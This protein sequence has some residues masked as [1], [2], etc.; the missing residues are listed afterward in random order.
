[1]RILGIEVDLRGWFRAA[2]YLVIA[3]TVNRYVGVFPT[4][5]SAEATGPALPDERVISGPTNLRS[6]TFQIAQSFPLSAI[7]RRDVNVNITEDRWS[8][9]PGNLRASTYHVSP[10]VPHQSNHK[11]KH[12]TAHREEMLRRREQRAAQL[13]SQ[14]QNLMPQYRRRR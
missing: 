4:K 1:M 12:T 2:L 7:S 5:G 10:K 11:H 6:S 8:N 3:D 13:E 9:A 14:E